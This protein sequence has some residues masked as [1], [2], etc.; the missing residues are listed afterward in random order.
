[1]IVAAMD[2]RRR[3]SMQADGDRRN[4]GPRGPA[5]T[6]R[7]LVLE[8]HLHLRKLL[9]M[10]L[11]QVRGSLGDPAPSRE[12]LRALVAEIRGVFAQHLTDEEELILPILE[13]DLP[14]GPQ[15]AK[16]LREEHARQRAEL[17]ALCTW[18]E[19]GSDHELAT[20]LSQLATALIEDIAHEER[21]VLIPEVIRD[22]H[23][24]IAQ[25]GG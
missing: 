16:A 4:E 5:E 2:G 14:L 13:D 23:V 8:Q 24:I 6:A 1:M 12:P 21:E 3:L 19:E 11:A 9:M 22:D 15:R 25:S 20:R 17:E 7:R 18:P 10:G